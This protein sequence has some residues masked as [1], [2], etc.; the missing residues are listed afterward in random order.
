MNLK[1]MVCIA[2]DLVKYYMYE[3][4]FNKTYNK[5]DVLEYTIQQ[6][7]PALFIVRN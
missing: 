3:N 4:R 1:C 2:L 6:V 5:L 7:L